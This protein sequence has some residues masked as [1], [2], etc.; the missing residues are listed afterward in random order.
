MLPWRPKGPS[1][2]PKASEALVPDF[3]P[4]VLLVSSNVDWCRYDAANVVM[5]VGF[6]DGGVYN[7]LQVPESVFVAFRNA[8]SHGKFLHRHVKPFFKAEEIA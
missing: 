6:K 3:G 1:A 8:Q 4:V 2:G 5:Q 7:Y